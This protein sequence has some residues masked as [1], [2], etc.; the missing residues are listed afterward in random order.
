MLTLFMF[1][2]CQSM[3]VQWRVS[4]LPPK[5]ILDSPTPTRCA[6][7][8]LHVVPVLLVEV[9]HVLPLEG[10]VLRVQLVVPGVLG[11]QLTLVVLGNL[12]SS[13]TWAHAASLALFNGLLFKMGLFDRS[14][15]SC[16]SFLLS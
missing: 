11:R 4:T 1:F 7:K 14:A 12:N 3:Y 15:T 16:I 9:F 5:N 13:N 8:Y 6:L 10:L 2:E